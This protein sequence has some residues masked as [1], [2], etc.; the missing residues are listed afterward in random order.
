MARPFTEQKSDRRLSIHPVMQK[1]GVAAE[2]LNH[3]GKNARAPKLLADELI[4]QLLAQVE[5]KDAA[6]ILG[7]SSLAGLPRK[8]LAER[9]LSAEL[10]HHLPAEVQQGRSDNHR[11][12]A[13][14][15]TVI[16]PSGELELDIPG[17]RQATFEP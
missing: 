2:G 17:D 3:G 11:N 14:P 10:T 7:E 16:T 13:N 12:G 8:R 6:S 15:K 4:D 1:S 5:N 9:M